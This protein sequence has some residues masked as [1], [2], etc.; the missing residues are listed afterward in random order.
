MSQRVFVLG[1][2]GATFDLIKP[3]AQAG[4]L[5]TLGRLLAEGAHGPLESTLPPVTSPAWPSF[6]TGV[7]PGKHGVFD[8]IQ[9]RAGSFN[10][11]NATSIRSPT[12]WELLSAAGRRIGVLNVPVTYPPPA[13]NGFLVA[14]LLAPARREIAFPPGF[15][16]RYEPELG[17]YRVTPG[18]QYKPGNEGAFIAD[19]HL[20]MERRTRYALRLMQTEPW[21]F[22]MVHYLALDVAQHALWRHMDPTHPLHDPASAAHYGNAIRDLYRRADDALAQFLDQLDGNT[23]VLIMSDHGFGPL[24]RVV[25]LNNLLL[26]A[27]LLHLKRQPVVRLRAGLFRR[28]LTPAAAYGLIAR[29]GL[30]NLV[31]RVSKQARNKVVDSFLSFE[32]VDWSR[33]LAYSMGHVGQIF[34]NRRGRE[35]HGIVGPA[36][37]EDVRRRVI[38]ALESLRDPDS[39]RPLLDRVIPG[40]EAAHGPYADQ[41]PDLHVILDGYRCIAFPLFAMDGRIITRQIRGDSGC[42]RREGIFLAWGPSVRA[43]AQIEGA[44]IIDLAP[45]ILHLMGLSVPEYMDGRPIEAVAGG[46]WSVVGNAWLADRPRDT[47][48]RPLSLEDEAEV[49]SRLRS[50]GYLG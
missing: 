25:N 27:G 12:L 21:D 23:V 50:L 16:A 40:E 43:G 30:Q 14:G 34:I 13:V 5:P 41:G 19:L 20:L 45:T 17:P 7:N 48:H 18:V 11:V 4:Y 1:L 39:G 8:F 32:D 37:V 35:P 33:T 24:H 31:W 49:E 10:L 29:F 15:L 6:M 44:R 9:A 38:A 47:D 2:D 26:Q 22:F 28:G 36:E 3:W 42:H 46:Q